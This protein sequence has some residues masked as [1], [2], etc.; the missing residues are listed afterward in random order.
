MSSFWIKRGGVP[1]EDTIFSQLFNALLDNACDLL[2]GFLHGQVIQPIRCHHHIWCKGHQ[3]QIFKESYRPGTIYCHTIFQGTTVPYF[4]LGYP[5]F[6][7]DY[8]NEKQKSLGASYGYS[9]QEMRASRMAGKS[10]DSRKAESARYQIDNL[11]NKI[12]WC[13]DA[14]SGLLGVLSNGTQVP[15]YTNSTGATSGKTKWTEKTADEI[16]ADVNGMAVAASVAAEISAA[17]F[18]DFII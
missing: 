1:V 4:S 9:A 11:N 8:G 15:T 6:S 14:A 12:A 3:S 7:C 18:L 16:L 17:S 5:L 13:G 2:R 10:L